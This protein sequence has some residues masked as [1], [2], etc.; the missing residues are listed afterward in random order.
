MAKRQTSLISLGFAK[1]PRVSPTEDTD[2]QGSEAD[3]PP[4]PSSDTEA[5]T[6]G[7]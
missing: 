7:S 1:K 4:G 2:V 5:Q 3:A 6:E